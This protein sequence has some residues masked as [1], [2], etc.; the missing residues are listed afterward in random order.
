MTLHEFNLLPL[1]ILEQQ[2]LIC[3]G[4]RAWVKRMLSFFPM[5]DLVELLED[6]EEQW[7]ACTVLDWKEGF[8]T[9][10]SIWEV[11]AL[12]NYKQGFSPTSIE[13]FSNIE[14][15]PEIT[16]NAIKNGEI[17]YQNKFEYKFIACTSG[18][19]ATEIL[20]LLTNRLLN[21]SA[22]EI[23]IAMDEQNKITLLRLQYL[24][25]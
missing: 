14:L 19:S 12:T 20:Q 2:L 11:N 21:T 7:F 8:S 13:P 6:A 10:Q 17:D 3:C 16:V 18:K 23:G 22:T 9:Q 1:N 24:L 15:F 25:S 5:E 4:S